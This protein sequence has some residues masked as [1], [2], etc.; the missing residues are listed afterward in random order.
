MSDVS[1]TDEQV[2]MLRH[3]VGADSRSPGFRNRYCTTE[4]NPDALALVKAGLF[5]GPYLTGGSVGGGYALFYATPTAF[6]LLG[7]KETQ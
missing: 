5:E 6:K 2:S 7:I 3:T 4:T 1:I